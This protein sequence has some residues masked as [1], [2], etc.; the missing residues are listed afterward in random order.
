MIE[1]ET[2]SLRPITVETGVLIS[3]KTEHK[4]YINEMISRD[5]RKYHLF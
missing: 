5:V 4:V 3:S 2:P 1:V